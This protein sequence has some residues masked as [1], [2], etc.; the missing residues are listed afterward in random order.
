VIR[1][2]VS[3]AALALTRKTD[4]CGS[5]LH[6]NAIQIRLMTIERL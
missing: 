2:V 5:G 1:G 3:K 6:P 4:A